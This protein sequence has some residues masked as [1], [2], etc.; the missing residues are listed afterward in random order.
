MTVNEFIAK[1]AGVT[2]GAER[3]N[4]GQFINDMCQALGLPIPGVAEG[5]VLGDYQFEG[6]V[7]GG[8]IGGNTGSIDLYKRG[9]FVLEAKQSKLSVAD[10]AQSQLFDV[11]ESAPAAPSGARYDRLMR[12]ALAQAKRYAVNLPASHPWPPFLIV[13]DVGRAFELYFDWSGNGRGFGYF[14]DQASYRLELHQL[15]DP[16]KQAIL[17]AIWTDPA[18]IDPRAKS[19]E[20]SRDIAKRL[21]E[22]SKWLESVQRLRTSEASDSERSLAIEETALFLM[23]LIFCMFAED[24]GLLPKASFR[25]FLERSVTNEAAF[26]PELRALWTVMGRAGG[27]RYASAIGKEVRYFN[28]GLFASAQTYKLSNADRGELLEAAKADWTKVEPAIFGTLLEQALTPGERAKLGA[29]Y[30]P[31]PYV[32]RLVQATIMDVLEAEWDAVQRPVEGELSL[33]I[34]QA[35][36]D[37][38]CV[39]RVLDPAC[40]TGNF[41]YVAMENLM[42]LESDVVETIRQLGGTVEP[43]VGPQQFLGLELNPRAAVIAEL[44]LWIGW[45]R[46]RMANDPAAAP[47]PVLKQFGN[48]NFGGHAGYDAVLRHKPTGEAD[49]D[50]PMAPDWPEA[51]FI[52][53]NP[54]FIAGQDLREE[55]GS[56]YAE[57]LWKANPRVPKAADFVMQWWDRAAHMLVA[58]NSPLIRFGFVTTNSITQTF[59]RR[60]IERYLA[61]NMLSLRYAVPDHPWVKPPKAEAKAKGVPRSKDRKKVAGTAAVR[62]AMTVADRNPAEGQIVTT[63]RESALDT[64]SPQVEYFPPVTGRINADLS[65]G[66]DVTQAARLLANAGICHDGVKLHGKAFALQRKEAE[67]LGLGRRDGLEQYIRPYRNGMDLTGRNPLEVETKMVID[68]FGVGE[69]EVRRRFPEVYQHL[70]DT[71]KPE[72]DKNRRATY[73]QNWW[74][75]GEPRREMRPALDGLIRY[76]GTVDT[77][78]HRLFQFLPAEVL[79]DDGV[80]IFCCATPVELGVLTSV[81]HLAWALA[82]GGT[83]EDRPRYFKSLCFDPFPFPD[84]TPAQRAVIGELAEELDETRKLALAEVPRLT[85][86]EIYN[87]RDR[88]RSGQLA[89]LLDVERAKAARVGII[90]RLHQ[91]IDAEVAAAY[92]WPADLSPAEIVTRLVALNAERAAEEKA[93]KVRWLRPEYQV[94]RFA[95]KKA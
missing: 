6:P 47:E 78:K 1:W 25:A 50:N 29:H 3:A 84:A 20:V 2:G 11:A 88:Q 76:I 63:K 94:P 80:V 10:K 70:L 68:L 48:I 75:H 13:C 82:V 23:R 19:A 58:A 93:E 71:V 26:E 35:F 27:E 67:A 60:V 49:T 33:A 18:S 31:R 79:C 64:D 30:T 86:T 42:R 12:D 62:I 14:P 39:L 21:A 89:D 4:Y 7:A 24:V 66:T 38:L 74:I 61:S 43:C 90:D 41:L 95:A 44:V 77:A 51:D 22:V 32:E 46:W 17:R 87:L 54:P 28:G 45:L 69:R 92:G 5:G 15:A 83:L 59:S 85:M 40:G 81:I 72:R 37:R 8:G 53:G 65:T 91:Q 73:R 9:C 56:D 57:A 16:D 36:H 34:V 55:L 52:I